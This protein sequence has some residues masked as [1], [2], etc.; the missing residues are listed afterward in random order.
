MEFKCSLADSTCKLLLPVG[1]KG[2]AGC[3]AVGAFSLTCPACGCHSKSR[4]G[5]KLWEEEACHV[6]SRGGSA[7]DG[8]LWLQHRHRSQRAARLIRLQDAGGG[9]GSRNACS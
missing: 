8:G 7:I 4:R 5:R 3:S 6:E 2:D 1:G 9:R